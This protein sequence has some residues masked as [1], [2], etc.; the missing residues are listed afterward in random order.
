MVRRFNRARWSAQDV[1]SLLEQLIRCYYFN[2]LSEEDHEDDDDV[3][4]M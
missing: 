4:L 1:R 3:G 2:L